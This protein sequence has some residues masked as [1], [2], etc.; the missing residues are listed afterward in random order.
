MKF[1]L[2][3]TPF[4]QI[5]DVGKKQGLRDSKEVFVKKKTINSDFKKI[6]L[7]NCPILKEIQLYASQYLRATRLFLLLTEML[8]LQ[9]V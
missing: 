3:T 1:D 7:K 5:H 9:S 6:Y 8:V 4:F 2:I